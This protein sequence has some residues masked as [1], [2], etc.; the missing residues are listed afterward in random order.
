MHKS[1]VH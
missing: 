1:D